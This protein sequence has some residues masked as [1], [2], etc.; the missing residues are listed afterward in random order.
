MAADGKAHGLTR[1][2]AIRMLAQHFRE[3]HPKSCHGCGRS[4][5]D[6]GT[7][8]RETSVLGAP[9]CCDGELGDWKPKRPAGTQA[10]SMCRCGTTLAV[11]SDAMTMPTMWSLLAWTA[12]TVVREGRPLAQVL[13][14]LRHDIDV[15][16]IGEEATAAR[17]G[18]RQAA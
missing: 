12:A 18:V 15:A 1:A 5:D 17:E 11:D 7:Y 16:L 8:L 10:Y 13:D 3:H 4:F 14:E 2:D 6:V 9:V